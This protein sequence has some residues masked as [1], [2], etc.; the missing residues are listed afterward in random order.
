MAAVCRGL[1]IDAAQR[2]LERWGDQTAC[3]VARAWLEGECP[4]ARVWV[5]V[6]VCVCVWVWVWV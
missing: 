2:V 1:P 3:L 5:W 4:P 6:W